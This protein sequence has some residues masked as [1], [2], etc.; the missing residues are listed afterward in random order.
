MVRDGSHAIGEPMILAVV[1]DQS[2]S[3]DLV[4]QF[5]TRVRDNSSLRAHFDH[6]AMLQ[7][8]LRLSREHLIGLEHFCHILIRPIALHEMEWVS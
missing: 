3:S 4:D 8:G 2:C 1:D 7:R 6:V 5:R